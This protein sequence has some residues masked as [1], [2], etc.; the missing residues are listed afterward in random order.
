MRRN[1]IIS[2]WVGKYSLNYGSA[3]Q[4]AA[5]QELVRRCGYA[6]ITVDN[7]YASGLLAALH[8]YYSYSRKLGMGYIR[9]SRKFRQF[10]WKYVKLSPMCKSDSEVVQYTKKKA[11][12]LL[13]GS[14][15]IW[16]KTWIRPLFLWD[17]EELEYP[18]IAYAPS[19]SKGVDINYV[20]MKKALEKFVA[21]SGR[22]LK[23]AEA[24]ADYTDKEVEVVLDPVLT[25][26]ELFWHK[27][28]KKRLIRESYVLCY[29]LS[30]PEYHAV[31]IDKVKKR[32]GV[33]KLVYIN[34]DY[35]DKGVRVYSDYRDYEYKGIVGPKEFYSLFKYASAVCTDSYH[36]MCF[37]IVFRKNF[38][39]FSRPGL[40]SLSSD[41]RFKSV[42]TQL[43]LSDRCVYKNLDITEMKDIDYSVIEKYLY[44][45]RT[46]SRKYLQDAINKCEEIISKNE[47]RC[48]G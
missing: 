33:E 21:L 37:S 44:E 30:N 15:A 32:Y 13:C 8:R 42:F 14:D 38:F 47:Y 35:I 31:S 1:V 11:D 41:N 48:K 10:Y 46:H 36:G 43:N 28:A 2:T 16:L 9:T 3:S 23:V 25:V 7:Y 27:K 22:E 12:I 26:D 34:T 39:I 24:V 4:T 17:Y 19:I 40:W 20:N 18:R 45:K 29:I 5:M 6:P